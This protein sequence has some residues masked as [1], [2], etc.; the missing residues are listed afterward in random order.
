MR[1]VKMGNLMLVEKQL[2]D[3]FILQKKL[4]CGLSRTVPFAYKAGYHS[5]DQTTR[6]GFGALEF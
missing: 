1:L 4:F 5:N 3:M 6:F 2:I